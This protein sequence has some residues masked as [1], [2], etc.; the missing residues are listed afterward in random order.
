M[1]NCSLEINGMGAVRAIYKEIKELF[2]I[3][4]LSAF[5]FQEFLD[6]LADVG[7]PPSNLIHEIHM[8]LLYPL[9]RQHITNQITSLKKKDSEATIPK[10][11]ASSCDSGLQ[12]Q[13]AA[14]RLDRIRWPAVLAVML[15][16]YASGENE[17]ELA[18][19]MLSKNYE[20]IAIET[21]IELLQWLLGQVINLPHVVE[22]ISTSL[23]FVRSKHRESKEKK[24][25]KQGGG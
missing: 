8:A 22:A 1:F 4:V 10:W 18:N 14:L 25:Q 12:A 13:D 16:Q 11:I 7:T 20:D 5:G 23:G 2:P 24:E 19:V 15:Q 3:L 21:R 6:S 17:R 9:L